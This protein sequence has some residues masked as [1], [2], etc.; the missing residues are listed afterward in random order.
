MNRSSNE[1]IKRNPNKNKR[2]GFTLLEVLITSLLMSLILA[3]LW[4]LS[5]VYSQSFKTGSFKIE[6]SQIVRSLRQQ[7]SDDIRGA[8]AI[9][10][11]KK[12]KP[13]TLT[14]KEALAQSQALFVQLDRNLSTADGNGGNS[15]SRNH[16]SF[17]NDSR[18]HSHNAHTNSDTRSNLTLSGQVKLSNGFNNGIGVSSSE[19]REQSSPK[20]RVGNPVSLPTFQLVGSR[21]SLQLQILQLIPQQGEHSVS[22][23]EKNG[24]QTMIPAPELRT[25]DYTF[26]PPV[27]FDFLDDESDFGNTN[28]TGEKEQPPPSG[29][30]RKERA[31]ILPSLLSRYKATRHQEEDEFDSQS[32]NQLDFTDSMLLN[33]IV[34]TGAHANEITW[35]PEVIAMEFRYYD[36]QV[37]Q[38]TWNS[39]ESKKLPVAIE[40]AFQIQSVVE[41]QKAAEKEI[42]LKDLDRTVETSLFDENRLEI[43]AQKRMEG[44]RKVVPTYRHLLKLPL[45]E[46]KRRKRGL[47]DNRRG[48]PHTNTSFDTSGRAT[49]PSSRIE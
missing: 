24:D 42:E 30:M 9:A 22:G 31:W 14:T 46:L 7:F 8:I 35:V 13:T 40:I 44:S 6:E 3:S 39:R 29:L 48:V 5:H 16:S 4:A 21:D 2:S 43:E 10:V 45:G 11:D 33:E 32:S 49:R 27:V 20:V 19:F 47:N 25:I 28:Q 37:W 36:G 34:R 15:N 18:S 41:Q 1:E 23:F 26:Q 12:S 38:S 17:S